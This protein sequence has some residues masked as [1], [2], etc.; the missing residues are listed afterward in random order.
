MTAAVQR[1][2]TRHAAATEGYFTCGGQACRPYDAYFSTPWLINAAAGDGDVIMGMPVKPP[3]GC[4]DRAENADVQCAFLQETAGCR[5]RV[6]R[7]RKAA[8]SCPQSGGE[9]ESYQAY[10]AAAGRPQVSG[11]STAGRT[12]YVVAGDGKVFNTPQPGYPLMPVT[13]GPQE[14]ILMANPLAARY[15]TDCFTPGALGRKYLSPR[16]KHYKMGLDAE[17]GSELM[18]GGLNSVTEGFQ[19]LTGD[20]TQ[21]TTPGTV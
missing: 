2:H 20:V 11:L 19:N 7:G 9:N 1:L 18:G 5:P 3:A 6:G 21:G 12:D 16:R 8:S 10:P 15:R 14:S 4:V 13:R 17:R